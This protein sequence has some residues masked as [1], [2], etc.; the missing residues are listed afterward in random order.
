MNPPPRSCPPGMLLFTLKQF[1]IASPG[2]N[3][4]SHAEDGN[5]PAGG[6]LFLIKT[7]IY[8]YESVTSGFFS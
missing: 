8:I 2:V 6:F 7:L 3:C 5:P 4:S 1:A